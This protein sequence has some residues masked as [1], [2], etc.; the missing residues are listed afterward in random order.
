M[1]SSHSAI[2]PVPLGPFD[3][4]R[5]IGRG[6]MAEVWLGVHR[7]QQQR[8]AV[9]VLTG[10]RAREE[11]FIRALKNEIHN[12]ARLHH[13]GIILLF[14]TGEVDDVAERVTGGRFAAGS[15]WF[16]MEL[17]SHGALSP[18]RLPLPWPTTR[19]L[20]LSL[21]D[22]LSHAH[23]RG[24]I[25]RDIK[26][27][28]ILLCAPDDP[29]PGLK[30]TDFGIAAPLGDHIDGEA[31]Q[32][33]LSG[34]P[35]Y[36]APEQF[37]ARWRDF[38]PWT[39]LYALGCIAYQLAT[40]KAPFSG[41]A[42][43]LAIA[44]CH[45]EPEPPQPKIAGFP[46]GFDAWV[47]RLLEKEPQ[48]RFACAADAAWALLKLAAG[49]EEHEPTVVAGWE[50]DL[51]SL[52]PLLDRSTPEGATMV[53][54]PPTGDH[55]DEGEANVS[56]RSGDRELSEPD[57]DP[58]PSSQQ[59]TAA[60]A[61][62][63]VTLVD[64]PKSGLASEL[65]PHRK[66][67]L[68]AEFRDDDPAREND[69]N[70]NTATKPRRKK[71]ALA[72]D[73]SEMFEV[74]EIDAHPITNPSSV[75]TR[76]RPRPLASSE[77]S[78]RS[79]ESDD[80]RSG[81]SA[82]G[83]RPKTDD[84]FS[85]DVGEPI[86]ESA[87]A[88]HDHDHDH[89]D[90]DDDHAFPP[91]APEDVTLARRK[92]KVA[93]SA[94][95]TVSSVPV[96]VGAPRLP[97][98][99]FKAQTDP[100]S[101]RARE[102]PSDDDVLEAIERSAPPAQGDATFSPNVPWT[103]LAMLSP[104][105]SMPT[106]TG[107][108]SDVNKARAEGENKKKRREE[109]DDAK[110]AP[111]APP[112]LPPTWRRP[113]RQAPVRHL[114]GAGLGLYGL[115]QI[116]LV[117]RD[118][119]RDAA[120]ETL[121]KVHEGGGARVLVV[122][123]PAG[124]GKSRLAE[125]LVE[126]AVEVG[127][128]FGLRAGHGPGGGP[129]DGLAGLV[130]LHARTI[131]LEKRALRRRLVEIVGRQGVREIEEALALG[132][133]LE[134]SQD[135]DPK[136][137]KSGAK[138]ANVKEKGT[139]KH[140]VPLVS[141]PDGGDG[142]KQTRDDEGQR[143]RL[144]SARER[145]AVALRYLARAAG[146]RPVV[147]WLDDVQWGSEAIAFARY[148]VDDKIARDARILVILSG[149]E[150]ALGERPL[151]AAA[152]EELVSSGR[153]SGR[154]VELRLPHLPEK[155][156]RALVEELL[157]L[158]EGLAEL[159]AARTAGNPLF[160]V[161]L[162]GDFV[163]RGV[164]EL[165][166]R[167]FA[168]KKGE[169][170]ALPD[171]LHG[172][173]STKIKRVISRTPPG[174]LEALELGAILG[175]AGDDGEWAAICEEGGV[176]L[177]PKL[178]D[179]LLVARLLVPDDGGLRFAHAMLRESVMRGA[180]EEGRLEK[181]HK[182][183]ARMLLKRYGTRRGTHERVGRHLVAAGDLE[184]ALPHLLTA[185]AEASR[186]VGYPQAH[187][188]LAERDGAVDRLGIPEDDIR[189]AE[190]WAMKAGLLVDEGRYDEALMWANL[191]LRYRNDPRHA[192]VLPA[193]LRVRGECSVRQA[194]WNEAEARFREALAASEAVNDL[195]NAMQSHVGLADASYYRGRMEDTGDHLARALGICQ[196]RGDEAGVAYCLWNSSYVA[197]W[198]G[199]L[200]QARD[201]MLRQQ[202]LARRA[203]HR[204][205]IANGR[206]ALGDLERMS[207]RYD[208]A[209]QRYEDALQLF[210]AIGSGKRRVV[211]VNMAMN[212]LARGNLEKARLLAEEL[213]PEVKKTGERVLSSLCHGVLA[214]VSA[215]ERRWDDHD[216]HIRGLQQPR[217]ETGL[218][219]G[220]IALL[221]EIIGDYVRQ[222]GDDERAALAYE[223]AIEIWAAIGR[224]DR[225]DSVE[226]ALGKLG[227]VK[228][229]QRPPPKLS[230]GK[231]KDK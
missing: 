110:L 28:N 169:R 47:L 61:S 114:L 50:Q 143:I 144:D 180:A 73:S 191:V 8:V 204:S 175:T 63:Q 130:A 217:K 10:E 124:I 149:N 211:R 170:A 53:L 79:S 214:A 215:H 148:V 228:Q 106:L 118:P 33:R 31:E 200:D 75:F 166:P 212:A 203:G 155:D 181:H 210:E 104:K 98:A 105:E 59:I 77:T 16:A 213:V 132:E 223:N 154:V 163:M 167:G 187:A 57:G 115:R 158:E 201:V 151:E 92:T 22:A 216:T 128:A 89:D 140:K 117:D 121:R 39:D 55:A 183:A 231:K 206:N 173:W 225:V 188:L 150:E 96:A 4:E 45:D 82:R 67:N 162:V 25:H 190:G 218:I 224:T 3:L 142:P 122:R 95:N 6:G 1:T 219:D 12:V 27:G 172:V 192:R 179:E 129:L 186:G 80:A 147:A 102:A 9:K 100:R 198:L 60:I 189:R 137:A 222:Q 176:E 43:R 34:T 184:A 131:G 160:A 226:R 171:D 40:G 21:L 113:G 116:P 159:V 11:A 66:Q 14:D 41:D 208:D 44:H 7:R 197:L 2:G 18:K 93:H 152:L 107:R 71:P 88:D 227:T 127:A 136:D 83:K 54:D 68:P 193:A 109:V 145:H 65:E 202:K 229:L 23:A 205:M 87:L 133:L 125:W 38:G 199:H 84:S 24:V 221:F 123:G 17:A 165:T 164:L 29:R 19:M 220:E 69:S 138:G 30:L 195:E 141:D 72:S 120:W 62:T 58:M 207:G 20:L 5:P 42:L 35:R 64:R 74:P 103:E 101:L 157:G 81:P 108:A 26:P 153:Q 139:S 48:R 46:E 52:K 209:E 91:I 156:H 86:R 178:A 76:H 13:P 94:E 49:P 56:K 78:L 196:E 185:A 174:S 182:T 126:R 90:G 119:E 70:E 177:S 85:I 51:R 32:G 99:P 230:S 194:K 161:Q 15:P 97:P 146:D 37:Q 111:R 135:V 112:P 134:P 168:L 36:M